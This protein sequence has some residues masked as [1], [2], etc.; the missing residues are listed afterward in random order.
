MRYFADYHTHSSFSPDGKVSMAELAEAA[1]GASLNEICFTDHCDLDDEDGRPVTGFD[2]APMFSQFEEARSRFGGKLK[3]RLG[4]ELG[5]ATHNEP[6]AER[7]IKD[8]GPDFVIGS[9]HNL[10]NTP[11]FFSLR[12]ASR[13]QCS[14]LI[15]PYLKELSELARWGGF[16]VLGHL[17]YPLR[18][19]RGRDGIDL[20]FSRYLDEIRTVFMSLADKGIGIELNTSGFRTMGEPMPPLELLKLYRR[21]GGETVTV[22]S[23]AHD[24]RY[25]GYMQKEGQELLSEAGFKYIAVFEKREPSYIKIG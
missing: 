6:L 22:G 18:Y 8:V 23:D 14:G 17:T 16:D 13:E 1:A 4:L 25:V 21:C 7:I 9:L 20:D 5:E 19:M 10:K 2:F 12:Y 3:L 24:A 11:D 15:E